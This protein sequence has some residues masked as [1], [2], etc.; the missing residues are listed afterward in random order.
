MAEAANDEIADISLDSND[1][2]ESEA[3]DGEQDP[4][5]WVGDPDEDFAIEGEPLVAKLPVFAIIAAAIAWA[6]FVVWAVLG[7]PAFAAASPIEIGEIIALASIPLALLGIIWLLLRRNSRSEAIRF[8]R[9]SEA[10][11]A[12]SRRLDSAISSI[13]AQLVEMRDLVSKDTDKL[14]NLGEEASNR[15][16]SIGADLR[17]AGGVIEERSKLLDSSAK[18]AREDVEVLLADLPRAERQA[19]A[20]SAGLRE[21]GVNAH[22]QA[23]SLDA[24]L[25]ALSERGREADELASGA[26]QRLA[27]NL[28]QIEGVAEVSARKLDETGDHIKAAVEDALGQADDAVSDA[29]RAVEEISRSLA[30]AVE[31][32]RAAFED[33][34]SEAGKSLDARIGEVREAVEA[35]EAKLALV[36]AGISGVNEEGTAK[37]G[38]LAETVS[39]LQDEIGA[40]GEQLGGND[41]AA[42]ALIARAAE[43]KAALDLGAETLKKTLPKAISAAEMR[44]GELTDL[45]RSVSPEMETLKGMAGDAKEYIAVSGESLGEQRDAIDAF[46]AQIGERI[47]AMR[48]DI[49]GIETSLTVSDEQAQSIASSSAPQ[50]IEA[51]LRVRETADQAAEK[52]RAAFG[53]VIPQSAAALSE[54]TN[55]AMD[56]VL[57]ERVES[58]IAELSAATEQA[59]AAAEQAAAQLH[60]K[61]AEVQSVSVAIERRL[62]EARA[63]AEDADMDGFARRVTLLIESL[64]S[65]AI[66]VTKIL[67][68][69]VT[70]TAWAAYLKGDRGIFA[71]RAVRLLDAGEAREI[72]SQYEFDAEF[73]EQVNRYVHDFEA[74]L[75]RVLATRDGA[76]VAVT[77]LSS[78]NGKLYVAL[79]QAIERF[80][81]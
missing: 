31:T 37:F 38:A 79:A 65:T 15:L 25:S 81:D 28:A 32:S 34:G 42:N 73:K 40:M 60:E 53:E 3:I 21:A 54:A 39:S 1:L 59:V 22:E 13:T 12:E 19:R 72:A 26:A 46:V 74:M 36:E 18:S 30:G 14:L 58:R 63:E 61:I 50:L 44:T 69:D 55:Q 68:N 47:A 17:A 49:A 7:D 66:D 35:V 6:G 75:R 51:L 77:L 4:A 45:V 2:D 43:M 52:A 10:L 27:A 24:Q 9:T 62:T 16:G 67:S 23:V 41:E 33:A 56:D 80:R 70:D 78:D 29:R 64:N 8:G 57:G 20:V 71:R 11:R 5:D 48:E 76:P